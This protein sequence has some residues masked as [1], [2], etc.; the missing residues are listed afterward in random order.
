MTNL[1][2]AGAILLLGLACSL[3]RAEC[4]RPLVVPVTITGFAATVVDG[5][6]HGIYPDLLREE[7]ARNGCAIDFQIVPRARQEM[8]FTTGHADVLVPAR[9]VARRDEDG[10]F[11]AMIRSRPVLM[12]M[13]SRAL[14]FHALPELLGRETLRVGIMRGYDYG[15]GYRAMVQ[16]LTAQHR[17]TD[18][19][20]PISLARML[21]DGSIDVA[22]ITPTAVTGALRADAKYR[23][24]IE[25]LRTEAVPELSWGESGAYVTRNA[26]LS[27]ADRQVVLR[28]LEHIAHSGAAWRGFQRY[29]PEPTLG[30]SIAPP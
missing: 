21:A 10:I 25:Q 14:T 11:V 20:D 13:A 1:R 9:R 27:D 2:S 26:S 3:A 19:T 16:Q 6:V 15:E 23:P 28:M 4:S 12:T 18:V 17:L 22:V 30:D 8:L 24:L 29:Y 7:A 5:Q